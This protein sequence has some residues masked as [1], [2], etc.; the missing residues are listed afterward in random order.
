MPTMPP[1]CLLHIGKTGGSFLRSII[2]HNAGRGRTD[3]RLLPHQGNA[4]SSAKR[5][6][7]DRRLAFVIR[8]PE[9]RFVSGFLSRM[10]QGRPTYEFNWSAEEAA[11]FMWFATPD[12]LAVALGSDDA[13]MQSAARF[14]MRSIEHLN[15]DYSYYF[16]SAEALAEER[17][18][19]AMCIDLPRL[20]A[21]LD[22]V[23]ERLGF[24]SYEMPPEP[25]HHANPAPLPA[26]SEA[27]RTALRAYW[28]EDWAI[29]EAALEVA[30]AQFP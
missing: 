1:I 8:D 28:A 23:M 27:G 3:L 24:D 11:A 20:S 25:R 7:A 12:Q 21:R 30:R 14:A 6:G 22:E 16:R 15:F 2:R 18:R 5:H 29:Y 26:L 19:I 17:D 10:R 4:T 13:R 9:T